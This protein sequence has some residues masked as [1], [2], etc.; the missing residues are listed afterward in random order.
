[1]CRTPATYE[2]Q[3]GQANQQSVSIARISKM[4]Q[5]RKD[6]AV[7]GSACPK[8]L[9]NNGAKLEKSSIQS[10]L[11]CEDGSVRGVVSVCDATDGDALV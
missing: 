1:M 10:P 5:P 4:I 6:V 8:I 2:G 9:A 11:C 7:S 3:A